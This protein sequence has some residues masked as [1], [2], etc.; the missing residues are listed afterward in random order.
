MF[1][2]LHKQVAEDRIRDANKNGSQ[3][4]MNPV[5]M[6]S[7]KYKG[8]ERPSS[9]GSAAVGST[10]TGD[11]G[12]VTNYNHLPHRQ[13]QGQDQSQQQATS[14]APE[15]KP[16]EAA[17]ITSQNVQGLVDE[18]GA[19]LT[20]MKQ[21]GEAAARR[22]GLGNT[23]IAGQAAMG[24]AIRGAASLGQADAQAIQQREQLAQQQQQHEDTI[25]QQQYE[26]TAT[27]SSN[28][29]GQ[30]ASALDEIM[31]QSAIS[32]N[33]IETSPDIKTADKNA[34]ITNSVNRRNS[35]LNFLKSL[36]NSMPQFNMNW[37]MFP[38]I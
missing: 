37:S 30:Y 7:F 5:T 17:D 29:Q 21:Q 33:E 1:K 14:Q 34:M 23:S 31:N 6:P 18:G 36:Y 26:L 19:Y 13:E 27:I 12:E 22:R 24:E 4:K 10:Y 11:K 3:Q 2:Q 20:Q 28:L 35:D 38:T 25:K 32:I 15:R 9:M 16:Y 8:R